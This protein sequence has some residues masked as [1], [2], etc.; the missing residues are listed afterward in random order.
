MR[1]VVDP[2]ILIELRLSKRLAKLTPA[3]R[4]GRIAVTSYSLKRLKKSARWRTWIE[5]N[6]AHVE[7]RLNP[8]REHEEFARLLT[9][10]CGEGANPRL[11]QD[12]VMAITI[13]LVRGWPLAMRDHNASRVAEALGVK[14]LGVDGL[15]SQL[16]G[17][18]GHQEP[19]L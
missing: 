12:D 9:E 4:S 8:G 13:S 5:R 6:Q 7:V 2:S 11:A 15:L 16:V 19:L 17:E 3:I 1:T 18:E 10:H 14:C